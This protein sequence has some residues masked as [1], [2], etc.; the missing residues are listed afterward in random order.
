MPIAAENPLGLRIPEPTAD[1]GEAMLQPRDVEEWITTLPMASGTESAKR[2][3]RAIQTSNRTAIPPQTRLQIADLY[4]RPIAY[5]IETLEQRFVDAA[6]PLS[7]KARRI[8]HVCARLNEEL[9]FAYKIVVHDVA[10]GKTGS[11]ERKVLI[12]ALFRAVQ[13]LAEMVYNAVLVYAPYPRHVWREL[14]NLFAFAETNRWAGTRVKSQLKGKATVT[15]LRDSYV[16]ALL[17][18]AACPYQMRQRDI[19]KLYQA[20]QEWAALAHLSPVQSGND[21]NNR[22]IVQL[23]KDQA[24]VYADLASH[25]IKKPALELNTSKLI[26]HLEESIRQPTSTPNTLSKNNLRHLT[27]CWG[28][29][30]HRRYERTQL[31]FDLEVAVGLSTIFTLISGVSEM[32][33]PAAASFDLGAVGDGEPS[34]L[35]P[36]STFSTEFLDHESGLTLVPLENADHIYFHGDHAD[37]ITEKEKGPPPSIWQQNGRGMEGDTTH[38]STLRTLNESAG[39]YCVNWRSIG[40]PGIKLGELVGIQSPGS[41]SSYGLTVVRWM[42]N[43]PD[44]GLHVGLELLAHKVFAVS[45]VD[46]DL[47]GDAPTK[48]LLVPESKAA[49]RPASLVTPLMPF[50][51]HSSLRVR[52]EDDERTIRLVRLLETTGAFAQFQFEYE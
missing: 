33:N 12:I 24:P 47:G 2:L 36:E 52:H 42:R 21:D 39:G 43:Q 31:N 29:A 32:T 38:T 17:L 41:E 46:L 37:A 14:H 3:F 15:T 44:D 45:A 20:L 28:A 13:H 23:Y 8:A 25:P 10:M 22:F 30:P 48:C 4:A 5:T 40:L 1:S 19:L 26:A 51:V 50:K 49:E 6:F 34:E 16:R 7:E 35:A 27:G 11:D 9:A 18:A